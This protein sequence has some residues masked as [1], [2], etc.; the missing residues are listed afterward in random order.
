M[1]EIRVQIQVGRESAKTVTDRHGHKESAVSECNFLQ[2]SIRFLIQKR[3]EKLGDTSARY[4]E[5]T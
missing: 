2:T 3:I 1:G 5:V 4:S